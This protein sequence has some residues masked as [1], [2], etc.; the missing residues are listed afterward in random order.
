MRVL[1]VFAS[2]HGSTGEVARFIADVLRE[3]GVESDITSAAVAGSAR[4]YDACLLG[5]AVHNGLWLPEMSFFVRRQRTSLAEKPLYLW[6]NCLRVTEP[7]G[8]AYVTNHYL[9]NILTGKLPFR[10]IGIFAGKIELDAIDKDEE[11]TLSFRYDGKKTPADLA[12]DY[13]DWDG[14]R[15]WA[16]QVAS[17]LADLKAD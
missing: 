1:I 7:E 16:E 13:R 9:P 8:Y 5:S 15:T 10:K 6:L 2:S 4:K 3:R 17:D 14:I 11:W 12:G